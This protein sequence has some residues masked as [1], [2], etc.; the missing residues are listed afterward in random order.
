LVIGHTVS[1]LSEWQDSSDG[2]NVGAVK[3]WAVIYLCKLDSGD[4]AAR[5]YSTNS[6]M[7]MQA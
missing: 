3:R 1:R 5:K 7:G 2:F 6:S 4:L